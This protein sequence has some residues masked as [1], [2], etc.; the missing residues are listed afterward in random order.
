M[1]FCVYCLKFAC[2]LCHCEEEALRRRGNPVT[3]IR[4]TLY[5]IAPGLPR[6]ITSSQ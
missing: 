5:H 1:G 2:I 4:L 3:I 6:R